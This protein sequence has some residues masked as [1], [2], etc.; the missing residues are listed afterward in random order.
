MTSH[1]IGILSD[2]HRNPQVVPALLNALQRADVQGIVLNGDLGDSP[3]HLAFTLDCAAKT[4]LPIYAQPGGHESM[5]SYV[6]TMYAVTAQYANVIDCTRHPKHRLGAIDAVFLP[7]SDWTAGGQYHLVSPDDVPSGTYI[8]TPQGLLTLDDTH[9]RKMIRHS[10]TEA[11]LMSV[12]NIDAL[13]ALVTDADRT[14]VFCHVPARHDNIENGV[15]MEYFGQNLADGSVMPGVML[16]EMIRRQYGDVSHEDAAAIALQNGF[17]FKRENRGN[18]ALRTAY[19][20]N[21]ITKT[22]S[23][24]FHESA[25]RAHDTDCMPVWPGE[26]VYDLA[27]MASYADAGLASVVELKDHTIGYEPITLL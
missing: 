12:T 2:T 15:D 8:R 20:R 10:T 17:V 13:D 26:Q 18:D 23:G 4:G 6:T 22:I 1:R 19:S 9:V 7:G 11:G 27:L 21:G 3:R 14:V 24:H 25:H 16:E 5:A